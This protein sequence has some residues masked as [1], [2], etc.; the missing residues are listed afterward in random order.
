ML[1]KVFASSITEYRQ[2]IREMQSYAKE[3]KSEYD[4]QQADQLTSLATWYENQLEQLDESFA[5]AKANA[6]KSTGNVTREVENVRK[7]FRTRMTKKIQAAQAA[8]V[9]EDRV[10]L[11]HRLRDVELNADHHRGDVLW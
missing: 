4:K 5:Q 6:R 9:N 8:L 7:A 1:R 3:K 11:M 2:Q 10:V